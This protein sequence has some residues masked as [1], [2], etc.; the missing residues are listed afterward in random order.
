MFDLAV[1]D[2]AGKERSNA[3]GRAGE[4]EIAGRKRDISRQR[5]DDVRHAPDQIAKVARLSQHAIDGERDAPPRRMA[6][7][8][9]GADRADGRGMV[10]A[11]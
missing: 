11:F 9:D 2:V 1:D 10:E 5:R 6:D 7:G 3:R 8:G 4:N